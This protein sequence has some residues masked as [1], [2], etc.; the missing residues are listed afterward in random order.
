MNGS[1]YATGGCIRTDRYWNQSSAYLCDADEGGEQEEYAKRSVGAVRFA[2][3]KARRPA[4]AEVVGGSCEHIQIK[5]L[6][7]SVFQLRMNDLK[8]RQSAT[9]ERRHQKYKSPL[10]SNLKCYS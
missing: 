10:R 5:F 9:T 8:V 2:E 3:G 1:C 7:N 4:A 6:V